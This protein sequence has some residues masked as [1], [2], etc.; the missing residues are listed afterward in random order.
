MRTVLQL[1]L[2]AV[3]RIKGFF[4]FV[5]ESHSAKGPVSVEAT[6]RLIWPSKGH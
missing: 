1:N 5:V 6:L 2:P 3:Q 4:S